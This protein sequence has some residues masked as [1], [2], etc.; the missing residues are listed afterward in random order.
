MARLKTIQVSEEA[1]K[2]L[3]EAKLA[4]E[5]RACRSISWSEFFMSLLKDVEKCT[6]KFINQ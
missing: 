6:E 5:K 1:F 2:A 4:A 3:F